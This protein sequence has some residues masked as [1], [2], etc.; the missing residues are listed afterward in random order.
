MLSPLFLLK[1]KRLLNKTILLIIPY[2]LLANNSTILKKK[3][4]K[5]LIDLPSQRKN[6]SLK[7]T[8]KRTIA[9]VEKMLLDLQKIKTEQTTS[10]ST[11]HAISRKKEETRFS[12]DSNSDSS[13]SASDKS[14][15]KLSE[16]K[17]F[18]EKLNPMSLTKN[19]Y[20]KPTPPDMQFEER[21]F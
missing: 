7:T 13:S 1:Q 15:F 12:K 2:I 19:W 10:T 18:F 9:K 4:E 17:R 11:A 6:L 3:T 20:S 21:F 14:V 16:I 8:Q 5:P